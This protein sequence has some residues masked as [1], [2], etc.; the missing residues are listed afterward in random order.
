MASLDCPGVP[1]TH[2]AQIISLTTLDVESVEK[3]FAENPNKIAC[4]I[5]DPMVWPIPDR[6]TIATIQEIVK[7]EGAL[8][9]FDEVV[10]GFRVAIGGAQEM[11][12]I[13]PDLA[14]YGKCIANGLPLSVLVGQEQWMEQI[15]LIN[16]GLTFGL[17]AVSIIA[18]IETISEIVELEVCSALAEKGRF[19]K[20][21][22]SKMCHDHAISSA[23]V[24]HDCRPEIWF[25]ETNGL[26]ADYCKNLIIHELA[27]KRVCTY[28]VFNLSYSH[29]QNDLD[30]IIDALER[31]LDKVKIAMK[32]PSSLEKRQLTDLQANITHLNSQLDQFHIELAQSKE[33]ITRLNNQ[34]SQSQI[35]LTQFK[36]D[37]TYLNNQLSQSHI[38]LAQSQKEIEAMMTSK[39]WKLRTV[40]FS[41][42]RKFGL[43]IT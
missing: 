40:W 41:I 17:E 13:V 20:Q 15:P 16:Y 26:S 1:T 31:G 38:E 30:A 36:E 4:L 39:F 12:D 18:A 24:G 6:E 10:S 23:L 14:C 25:E 7:R 37:I 9:I 22:Y 32:Y 27:R 35:E 43:P 34:L 21:A 33:D 8:L 29:N 28:G 5:L 2:H 11:W 19:L 42:K 3:V